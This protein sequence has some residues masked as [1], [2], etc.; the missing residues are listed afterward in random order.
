[1]GPPGWLSTTRAMAL[2]AGKGSTG[3]HVWCVMLGGPSGSVRTKVSALQEV[4]RHLEVNADAGG[5][6]VAHRL[7]IVP[8]SSAHVDRLLDDGG[9]PV[10]E[11]KVEIKIVERAPAR[12]GV[13]VSELCRG[14]KTG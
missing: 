13:P 6:V 9:P 12:V 11:G 10:L 3:R 1:M 4:G 14:Q 5:K 7:G 2:G 8:R